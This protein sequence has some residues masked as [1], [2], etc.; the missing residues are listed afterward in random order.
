MQFKLPSKFPPSL[1]D[2]MLLLQFQAKEIP[3]L[4]FLSVALPRD[5]ISPYKSL[6]AYFINDSV[7]VAVGLVPLPTQ[8][9]HR[10]L[11]GWSLFLH[12]TH[13][14]QTA[15]IFTERLIR[16]FISFMGLLA[17]MSFSPENL[18]SHH[19]NGQGGFLTAA[20]QRSDLNEGRSKN[21]CSVSLNLQHFYNKSNT[22]CLAQALFSNGIAFIL[23]LFP[24]PVSWLQ[25]KLT[26]VLIGQ[27][28]GT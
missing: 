7:I 22:A 14:T 16:Y 19:K 15:H 23:L 28:R 27:K 1:L 17:R 10:Q 8:T 26:A 6:L 25:L 12:K 9:K 24:V 21:K 5:V 4:C 2:G 13:V 18:L 3:C 20:H 11:T